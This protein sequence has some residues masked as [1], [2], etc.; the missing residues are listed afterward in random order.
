VWSGKHR[1]YQS[2][3]YE[4][5]DAIFPDVYSLYYT[6]ADRQ[7][8]WS[9]QEDDAWQF[10]EYV[11]WNI[12]QAVEVAQGKPVIAFV[13]IRYHENARHYTGQFLNDFNLQKS[14]TIPRQYGANG[15]ALWEA[16][17]STERAAADQ[18]YINEKMV[19]AIRASFTDASGNP[20]APSAPLQAGPDS[21][22]QEPPGAG[23]AGSNTTPLTTDDPLRTRPYVSVY[24]DP[25]PPVNPSGSNG[26]GPAD[27]ASPTPRTPN[28]RGT[29]NVPRNVRS[30]TRGNH[31]PSWPAIVQRRVSTTN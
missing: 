18:A 11:R 14:F 13:F 9:I 4:C 30:N 24:P 27:T 7:P 29:V 21:G 6:V 26:N 17:D 28:R 16:I 10:E 3:L 19:P 20:L 2:W 25:E 1:P 12:T 5:A 15:V 22:S 31:N 8:D 23:T